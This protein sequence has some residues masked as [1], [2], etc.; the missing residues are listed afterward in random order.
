MRFRDPVKPHQDAGIPVT[1]RTW[2]DETIGEEDVSG[3]IFQDCVF[4]RVR[5]VRANLAQTMFLHC[6]FDA[7]VFDACHVVQTRWIECEGEGFEVTNGTLAEVLVSQGH[8]ERL[9]IA[10]AARQVVLAQATIDTLVFDDAG[11]D[12]DLLTV[13]QCTLGAVVADGA[14]WQ[15]ASAL[16]VDLDAWRVDDAVFERCCFI[17]AKAVEK[18]LSRVRFDGCNL[19]QSDL[20]AARLRH[21][22]ASLFAECTLDH[23]DCREAA[24]EG[25]LF[26]KASARHARFDDA[27]LEGALLPEATLD[28]A[29]FANASARHSVWTQASLR[30]ARLEGLDAY[31]STWRNACLDGAQLEGLSLVE[32]DLHGVDVASLD[33]ADTRDAR[34]TVEW[35]A[36]V[37]AAHALERQ[38]SP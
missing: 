15:N 4:E 28:H 2:R 5:I 25:A 3:V 30:S 27:R 17:R 11:V 33:A 37:E 21:A 35:R 10:Q 29:S 34:P 24:L 12:Q 19:Y 7:C 6:R 18:D 36:E 20:R 1:E 38:A 13:G 23:A 32:A 8:L 22:Q 26:A 14:R 9:R 16:E 31:R